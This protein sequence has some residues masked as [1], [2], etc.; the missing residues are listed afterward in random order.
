MK[1]VN[2]SLD[3]SREEL[4]SALK[5]GDAVNEGVRFDEKHGKPVF[6]V[7]EKGNTLRIVAE[8]VGGA[9]KD[10]GFLVGTYFV[11]KIREKEN[12]V[13]LRGVITTAPIYHLGLLLLFAY[14]IYKCIS[15]GGFSPIPIIL[16]GFSIFLF[17]DE[18]RKQGLIKRFINRAA[19]FAAGK[20]S[21]D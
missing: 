5:I 7:R 9:S 18:F 8:Y 1:L 6:K 10:N 19:R 20:R 13:A 12:G 11:G 15:L 21:A 16:V 17:K 14:F 4:L 2:I 3:I